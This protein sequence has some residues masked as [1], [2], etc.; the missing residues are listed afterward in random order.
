MGLA[1]IRP[2]STSYQ[3]TG[4]LAACMHALRM[5]ARREERRADHAADCARALE[6]FD[7]AA[8]ANPFWIRARQLRATAI[9]YRA[10]AYAIQV[11]LTM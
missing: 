11:D 10:Q 4:V 9:I 3:K 2:V 6:R 1:T 8:L 5:T 7:L